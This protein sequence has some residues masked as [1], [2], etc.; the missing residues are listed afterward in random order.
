[1]ITKRERE[2]DMDGLF[3]I[4]M[5]YLLGTLSPSALLSKLKKKDIREHGTKNLG[6]LNTLIN[7]GKAWGVFVM[8]F[9]ILKAVLAVRIAKYWMPNLLCA[10]YLAGGAAVLGHMYPFYLKFKGGKGLA[11][12]A[13]FVLANDPV[14][15]LILF[16]LCV[17]LMFII[18]YSVALPFS[19]SLLYPFMA[20]YRAG[21]IVSFFAVFFVSIFMI[22]KF[23]GNFMKAL[24]G[25]DTKVRDFIRM[26]FSK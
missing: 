3:C 1:M 14:C 10:G 25:E 4:M 16:V 19:A 9:D 12:F 8:A 2:I 15:F 20:G 6:A 24:R 18:N 7:F 26:Q 21:D 13:G 11:P 23:Y 17:S 22:V 5:G